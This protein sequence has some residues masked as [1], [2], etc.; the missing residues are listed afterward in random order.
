MEFLT[1]CQEQLQ[2]LGLVESRGVDFIA[3]QFRGP[4]RQWWRSYV[5]T[6]PAG[7]PPITWAAFIEVF[8]ARY[9]PRSLRDRL[10][11]Q[12]TRL[13]QGQMSV[14]EYEARFHQLSRHATVILPTEEERVRCFVRG[15][16]PHLRLGTEHLVT[17]G[18]TFLDVVDHARTIEFIHRQAQGS[19]DKRARRQG[20]FSGSQSRGRGSYDRSR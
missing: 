2:S 8:L 10:R 1:T 16:R 5:Q 20:R 14:S 19:G 17:V 13:E 12:F 3:H 7:S 6:R 15:L 11:D 4:A 9:M 18:W